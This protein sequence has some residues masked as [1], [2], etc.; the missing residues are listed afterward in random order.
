[1][2]TRVVVVQWFV[3]LRKNEV[4]S[5]S[6]MTEKNQ[7]LA[8][9]GWITAAILA[10]FMCLT[11]LGV[12][13][14]LLVGRWGMAGVAPVALILA[15]M[16][17][18]LLGRQMK[19]TGRQRI[20][21][22]VLALGVM[23]AG[24]LM[25]AFY[26]DLSWDGQWYHQWGIYLIADDWNP[27]TEP[28]RDFTPQLHTSVRHFPKGPWYMA[29]AIY[30]A[31]GN[32][33]A[34]KCPAVLSWVTMGLAVF[35]AGLEWG[36]KRRA[37]VAIALVVALNPVVMSELTT[38]LVDGIMV[39]FLTVVVAALF[40]VF[41]RPQPVVMWVG[42]MA[43]ILCVNAKFTGPV[44]LAFVFA[45]GGLWCLLRRRTWALAYTGWV[46]LAL[47]LGT[48]VFGYNP[49]VTNT[50]YKHQ[51]FYPILGSTDPVSVKGDNNERWETPKNMMGR[52]R[53]V[54]FGYSIFGRPVN[55]PYPDATHGK[56]VLNA[57]LMWPFTARVADLHAYCY[58]ETRVA[59]FG[60]WFSGA[61]LISLGLAG[62]ALWQLRAARWVLLLAWLTIVGSLMVSVHMWWPRF[63]PQLWWLP[64]M[65]AALVF[66]SGQSRRA[67]GVAWVLVGL[68]VVNAGIVTGVRMNWET[69]ASEKLR[70]QLTELRES[71]K[72]IEICFNSFVRSGEERMK[73]WGIP[74][75][76]K[77]RK[78]LHT[79]T[80]LMSVVEGY[81]LAVQYRV[82]EDAVTATNQV[83][84]TEAQSAQRPIISTTEPMIGD[85]H[86]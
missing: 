4:T 80:E 59:G 20:W 75:H 62:W 30:E 58:H 55:A 85:K 69:R 34:G 82:L 66:W 11:Q 23:A 43:T 22:P 81:P 68:L 13:L 28:M 36:L 15:L 46:A 29:A 52:S 65:P 37:A 73:T 27:L 79:G 9:V 70:Q 19:L 39:A 57:E 33:E 26:F 32:F 5:I 40:S 8:A 72:E 77:T 24:L 17:G 64:I 3:K 49:Y 35:A 56:P 63:G 41:L 48:V 61:F 38:Y 12:M 67:I 2:G 1:L 54:R 53:W 18:E 21:P 78:E 84:A 45:A 47:V 76:E 31:T 25:S 7:S 50:I 44:F 71:G 6:T 42:C 83:I 16:L 14:S 10:G 86:R 60:P 74:Y 51:P